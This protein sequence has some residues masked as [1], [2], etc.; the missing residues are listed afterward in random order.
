MKPLARESEAAFIPPELPCAEALCRAYGVDPAQLERALYASARDFLARP[1][2]AFRARM[3]ER[4]HQLAGGTRAPREALDA[5]ELLHAGSLIIDDVQDDAEQRRGAPAMHRTLGTPRAINLGNW[6]YFEALARLDALPHTLAR[7]AH[8]CLARCHQGQ[9]LDLSLRVGELRRSDVAALVRFV[10]AL[11]TGALLGF[12]A[13]LGATTAGASPELVANLVTFGERVGVALQ[14]LDDLGSIA[15]EAR[16]DKGREDLRGQRPTWVWA[17]ASE[18]LDELSY[19]QMLKLLERTELEELRTRL[20]LA[21]EPLGR[22][23]VDAA[24]GEARDTLSSLPVSSQVVARVRD[25]LNHLAR[26]YG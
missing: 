15:C 2:K 5:V 26:S 25:E 1:G 23:R 11:K 4:C 8:H 21:V 14:M 9:A 16:F 7:S 3:V 12:A 18:A 6:L 24:I 20:Q 17:W 19:K 10:S 22:A 13:E